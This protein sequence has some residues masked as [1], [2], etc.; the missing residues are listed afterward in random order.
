MKIKNSTIISFLWVAVLV[1]R[2]FINMESSFLPSPLYMYYICSALLIICIVTD[3]ILSHNTLKKGSLLWWSI[4][5]ILYSVVFG[6]IFANKK[7]SSLISFNLLSMITFYILIFA[8]ASYFNNTQ[9]VYTFV[10]ISFWTLT[11]SML[12]MMIVNWDG[13]FNFGELVSN[14]FSGYT[15]TRA[16]FG[17]DHPNSTANI[18]LCIILI[19]YILLLKSQK[20]EKIILIVIDCIMLFVILES[21][22]RTSLFA[23][24]LFVV[25]CLFCHFK[26]RIKSRKGSFAIYALLIVAV[27]LIISVSNSDLIT[28]IFIASNRSY[29]FIYNLPV[30]VSSG[31]LFVG[32]GFI[33]SGEFMQL[34]QYNT[35]FV[36]NYFLYV[37]MSTGIIGFVFI[38][39][40]IV[41]L[42]YK[43]FNKKYGY[44]QLKQIVGLILLVNI[45]SSMGETCFMYPSFISCFVYTVLYLSLACNDKKSLI[46][47]SKR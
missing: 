6:V 43:L 35:F 17:F 9:K 22:S 46:K 31:R 37:L 25:M 41:F 21:A 33:G 16:A 27:I 18:A 28:N 2:I 12:F 29:N 39:A 5:F 8:V 40:F 14:V 3:R 1:S 7:L 4:A 11:T 13:N 36:D 32:L 45:F 15:R 23:L 47:R 19:S 34:T 10:K 20:N 30:L 38:C 26:K 42:I 44:N 24:I